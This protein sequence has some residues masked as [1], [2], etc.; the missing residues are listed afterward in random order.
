MPAGEFAA[1]SGAKLVVGTCDRD[2][3]DCR[4]KSSCTGKHSSSG[5]LDFDVG[6][7]M[8]STVVP[9]VAE[10]GEGVLAFV[11]ESSTGGEAVGAAG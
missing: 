8:R 7:E 10:G 6:E 5:A 4:P 9:A 11:G 2:G 1:G 3:L